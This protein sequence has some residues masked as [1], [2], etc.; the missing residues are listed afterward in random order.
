ME[1]TINAQLD[2]KVNAYKSFVTDE[3][4]GEAKFDPITA[5][6]KVAVL[7]KSQSGRGFLAAQ[8]R[9]QMLREL[10]YEGRARLLLDMY[11]LVNAEEAVFDA[12]VDVPAAEMSINGMPVISEIKS[13]RQRIETSQITSTFLVKWNE[14]SYRK[15]DV[16]DASRKRGQA[17]VQLQ[18]DF[19]FYDLLSF[20]AALTNQSPVLSLAGTTAATNNPDSFDSDEAGKVSPIDVARAIGKLRAKLMPIGAAFLNPE[21]LAD[22]LLFNV[23]T[24]SKG[25]GGYGIFAPAIQEETMKTG[26]IGEIF[27]VPMYD[28][29]VVPTDEVYVLAPKEYLGKFVIRADIEVKYISDVAKAGDLFSIIED[30]GMAMRYAKG[31][32]L[33]N[34]V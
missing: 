9:E 21:K 20:A 4:S 16:M 25:T 7:S 5:S 22:F 14:Q 6:K 15:F 30:I 33:I 11:T 1:D 2:E 24:T 32:V 31:I 17:S 10:L 29:V 27:G 34:I 8:M 23:S 3:M 18:E 13:D 19:R 12:D 28:S 26:L